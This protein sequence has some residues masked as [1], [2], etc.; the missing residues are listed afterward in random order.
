MRARTLLLVAGGLA[1]VF[2]LFIISIT[3]RSVPQ[4][5]IEIKG[6]S[7]AKITLIPGVGD[8]MDT[9]INTRSSWCVVALIVIVAYFRRASR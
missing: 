2:V 9:G 5:L 8:A 1:V 4:P 7:I 6:E 3:Y